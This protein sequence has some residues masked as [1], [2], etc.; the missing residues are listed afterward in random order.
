[1]GIT[2]KIDNKALVIAINGRFSFDQHN[3]FRATYK[4]INRDTNI[5][6]TVDLQHADYMDS[7]ALGMLLLLDEHFT[8]Q[9]INISN[10]SAYIREVF[11]IVNFEKKFNIS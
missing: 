10:C 6:V 4:D 3:A 9:R 7:A 11:S 1:M 8:K 2:K 5:N